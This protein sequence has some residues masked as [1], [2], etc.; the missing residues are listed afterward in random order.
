MGEGHRHILEEGGADEIPDLGKRRKRVEKKNH[1]W[2]PD[3]STFEMGRMIGTAAG[4][5]EA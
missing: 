4:T 1:R 2:G 5:A 3:M